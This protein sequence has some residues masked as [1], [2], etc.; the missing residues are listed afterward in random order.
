M[1][2]LGVVQDAQSSNSMMSPVSTSRSVNVQKKSDTP[3]LAESFIEDMATRIQ[4]KLT[5]IDK[6][7]EHLCHCD[8]VEKET[9]YVDE[10]IKLQEQMSTREIIRDIYGIS[11]PRNPMPTLKH[12]SESITPTP[13]D[14]Y[15]NSKM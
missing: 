7:T 12:K 3:E 1:S 2:T 6:V 10:E 14:S 13:I 11:Q 4:T 8:T 9:D 5:V 15:A